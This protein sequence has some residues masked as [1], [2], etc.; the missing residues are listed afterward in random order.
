MPTPTSSLSGSERRR[1]RSDDLATALR[2][3]LA[4]QRNR[5]GLTHLVLAD[6][7]GMLMAWDGDPA[8]CEELAAYA[9]FVARGE[10]LAIDPRR[11]LH[12]TVHSVRAGRDELLLV[13]RGSGQTDRCAAALQA[14]IEGVARILSR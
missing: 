1:N 3:L 9:P 12:V 11:L 5:A 13:L 7:E 6:H 14:S 4:S 2:F 10:G 8:E